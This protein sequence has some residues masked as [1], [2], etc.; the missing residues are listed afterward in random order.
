MLVVSW[1]SHSAMEP[2]AW[3]LALFLDQQ[4]FKALPEFILIQ[5]IKIQ[6]W[7]QY[8][9]QFMI[10]YFFSIN[11]I[12]IKVYQ[13]KIGLCNAK[14]YTT[15]QGTVKIYLTKP[16]IWVIRNEILKFYWPINTHAT[17]SSLVG[18]RALCSKPAVLK[19]IIM[20]RPASHKEHKWNYL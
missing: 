18:I 16:L 4:L 13:I 10:E 11:S 1:P 8:L 12:C 20:T 2:I 6:Y 17:T 9:L 19:W 14:Y 3:K 7:W 15:G 5:K